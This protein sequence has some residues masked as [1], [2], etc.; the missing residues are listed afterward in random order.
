MN[1]A[2]LLAEIRKFDP[3]LP[4]EEAWTPP[5]S[6]YT[7]AEVYALERAAVFSRTWQ[8]VA[9]VDQLPERG[10]YL[11]GCTAGE[12]WVVLRDA[13]GAIRA[14]HNVCRHKGRE[15]AQG[16]G[17][18]MELVCGY[19]A[20]SYGL[21]G[22]LMSAPRMAGIRNFD[23]ESMSLVPLRAETWG[24]WIF[25]NADLQAP[26]LVSRLKALDARLESGSWGELK[27]FASREWTIECNWKVYADNYLD[28]GYH[29]PHVHPTLDA[30]LDMT[31]YRTEVFGEFSIQS[32]DPAQTPD[33][34][35]DYDARERIGPEA[36]YAWI[37]PNLMLNRYGPCMDSN[38]ILPLGPERCRVVYDFFFRETA[39][40]D[41]RRFVEESVEQS[42]ITQREDIA[43]CESVQVGLGSSSYDRGRYAPQ[44]ELGEHHFHGLLRR[45]LERGLGRLT[46]P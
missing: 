7:S 18:A 16:A 32:S 4:I 21:D 44:V 22:R 1:H 17:N 39:G 38:Y 29:V 6:W 15:V 37:Y 5:A 13:Q 36:I 2:R 20:W 10:D 27:F 34:R 28:G 46:Q 30:Q 43:I 8:P 31:S 45:D 42:E 40:D 24:P 33:D 23:R 9:R 25:L 41:A 12:P 3:D 11:S 19:H 14:F 26:P 35:I